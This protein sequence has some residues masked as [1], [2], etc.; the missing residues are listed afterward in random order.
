MWITDTARG[1]AV[2]VILFGVF[3]FWSTKKPWLMQIFSWSDWNLY[4]GKGEV[5]RDRVAKLGAI[6]GGAV[7]IVL[8]VIVFLWK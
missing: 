6:I 3:L 2:F 8:G 1:V 5:D 7:L 4:E